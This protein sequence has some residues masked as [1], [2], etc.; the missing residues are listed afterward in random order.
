MYLNDYFSQL[1]QTLAPA[2]DSALLNRK[3]EPITALLRGNSVSQ[4]PSCWLSY[5][6]CADVVADTLLATDEYLTYADSEQQQ[7]S[8]IGDLCN[9]ANKRLIVTVR[10]FKNDSYRTDSD[11]VFSLTTDTS[12]YCVFDV[13][14]WNKEDRQQWQQTTYLT[15]YALAEDNVTAVIAGTVNRR[16]LYF[17]QLA[18]FC[19][20]AGA[21]TFTVQTQGVLKPMFRKHS[22]HII[23]VDF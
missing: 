7:I 11:R 17:K 5:P 23:V 22:E 2:V 1:K 8:A 19:F 13:V 9:R 15:G 10:D 6:S 18:K 14:Q 20:D 4:T 16:T 12:Q 3:Y 21:K